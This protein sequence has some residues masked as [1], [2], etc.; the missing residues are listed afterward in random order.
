MAFAGINIG[1]ATMPGHHSGCTVFLCPPQTVGGVDMRGPAS[2]S[3][4]TAL[5]QPDKPNHFVNAV[6]LTGGSAFGLATADGVMRYCAERG[7]GHPT[8]VRPVPIVPAAVVYDL[9]W[10]AVSGCRTRS[11]AMKRASTRCRTTMPRA[12]SAPAPG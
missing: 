11:W 10:D 2:S 4:E 12:M 3:R 7:L 8:P 9:F 5:L 6:V 1:H